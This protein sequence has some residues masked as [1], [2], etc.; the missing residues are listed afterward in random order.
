MP[1]EPSVPVD[2]PAGPEVPAPGSDVV[3]EPDSQAAA[4]WRYPAG[5]TVAR[6]ELD[7]YTVRASDGAIGRVL[8]GGAAGG[9]HYLLV[10]TAGGTLMI[11][12][13]LLAG[14]DRS[15]RTVHAARTRAQLVASPHLDSDRWA[16]RAYRIELEAHH[17]V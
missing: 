10:T 1:S 11:P 16:D 4:L 7:G 14:V 12:A 13:G 15:R 3:P 9:Q 17:A 8:A 6:D 5:I 2:P